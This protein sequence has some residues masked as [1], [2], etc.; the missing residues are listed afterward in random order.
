MTPDEPSLS[1]DRAVASVV[2]TV[3]LVAV[4]V[5]LAATVAVFVLDVG[6]EVRDPGPNV[7]DSS[8]EFV[9]QDGFD[10]GIIRITHLA[11]ESVPVS[12]L[13][14]AV[15]A[16]DA[17]GERARIVNLPSEAVNF[18]FPGFSNENLVRG[19]QSIVSKGTFDSEWNSGVLHEQNSNTF[20]A[21][22]SFEFRIKGGTD[23]CQL[24]SGDEVVVR[25]IHVPTSSIMVT[26]ELTA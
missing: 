6:E 21:G 2:S 3:L 12:E 1:G 26:E 11:G 14:I 17:C 23:D 5:I 22:S 15:D 10:G 16:T 7:A 19:D 25:V 4:V 13:E 24:S 8:G 20:A 18:G 9:R